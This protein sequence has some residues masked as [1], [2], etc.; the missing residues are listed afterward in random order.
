[1]EVCKNI[2]WSEESQFLLFHADGR[3]RL[4]RKPHEYMHPSF[5]MSTLQAGG[6]RVLGMFPWHT[7]GPLIKVEQRLNTIGYL[8]IIARCILSWQQC[9]HLQIDFFFCRIMP[10][11]TTLGLSRNVS[12][13]MTVT[14]DYCSGLPSHQISIQLSICGIRWN[15]LFGVEIHNQPT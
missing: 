15:E 2:A 7:L 6:V 13:K 9:I 14:S 12:T 1:M 3:T 5:R 11:S 10:H 8:N 4:W